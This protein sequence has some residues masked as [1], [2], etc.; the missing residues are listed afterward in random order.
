MTDKLTATKPLMI[1]GDQ[2]LLALDVLWFAR[3]MFIALGNL[4]EEERHRFSMRRVSEI[5]HRLRVPG[6][7][8][9]A[10]GEIANN[11]YPGSDVHRFLRSNAT[12]VAN[13]TLD[14]MPLLQHKDDDRSFWWKTHFAVPLLRAI[15]SGELTEEDFKEEAR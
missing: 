11:S 8:H 13:V 5:V 9:F 2:L 6:Y 12:A 10:D 4:T 1:R 14:A 3:F 15:A 7:P